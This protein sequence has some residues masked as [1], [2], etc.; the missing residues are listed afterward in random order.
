MALPTDEQLATLIAIVEAGTFDAAAAALGLTPSA[1]SQ[2]VKALETAVGQAVLNRTRPITPTRAGEILVSLA[3]RQAALRA[4]TRLAL[5]EDPG[6]RELSVAVNA[7]SLSTWF[8]GI[9]PIVAGW[10]GFTLRL[11]PDDQEFTAGL[12]RSG[13]VMGAVT[14]DPVAVQGSSVEYLG[15]MRYLPVA[16]VRFAERWRTENGWDWAAMPLLRYNDKD[17]LQHQLLPEGAAPPVHLVPT[18]TGFAHAVYAGMGWG[19]LPEEHA[20]GG[21]AD[22]RLV[23]L[24]RDPIEVRLY[25]QTWKLRTEGGDL[26][27][28]AVRAAAG[29]LA[30]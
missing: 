11:F 7:D 13:Q 9:Y 1:V 2:R 14:A 10:S 30:R 29:S 26:L 18:S 28:A 27:T 21:L 24:G 5:G 20:R 12:L 23:S 6:L 4:E 22:G 25:W 19:S 3:R 16:A 17:Q 15:K 8:R